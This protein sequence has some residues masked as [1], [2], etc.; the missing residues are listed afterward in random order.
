MAPIISRST[1]PGSGK[2]DQQIECGAGTPSEQEQFSAALRA[3]IVATKGL[4]ESTPPTM[5]LRIAAALLPGGA[6][7]SLAWVEH[8][9]EVPAAELADMAAVAKKLM[10]K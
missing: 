7:A 10:G 4:V 1:L 3:H 2:D 6:A 9:W 8:A 5:L